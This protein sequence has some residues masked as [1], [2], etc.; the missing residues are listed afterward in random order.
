MIREG[1]IVYPG[2]VYGAGFTTGHFA[3]IREGCVIGDDVSIGSYTEIGHH[4][5]ISNGVR[6]HSRCFVPEYTEIRD[7]AWLG[8]GVT[9]TN[10][11]HPLCP[12]AKVC[13]RSTRV[14]IEE[15]AVVCAGALLLP[16]ITVKRGAFVAAGAIVTR[17]VPPDSAVMGCPARLF[18]MRDELE[19]KRPFLI[20][21]EK[22]EYAYP[23]D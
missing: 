3:L 22:H 17:N 8:P 20:E 7:G 1:T 10:T 16:G 15:S 2:T 14:I 12:R 5:Q 23:T 21:G 13:L 6:I 9:I 4:V 11:F 19:C 18:K